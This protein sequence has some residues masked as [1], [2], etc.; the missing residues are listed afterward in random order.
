MIKTY[1]DLITY[2]EN[3]Q[4]S[5]EYY[6]L[7]KEASELDLMD[8]YIISHQYAA[9]VESSDLMDEILMEAIDP[10]KLKRIVTNFGTKASEFG[11]KI[12]QKLKEFI[13]K[14]IKFFKTY[15]NKLF[16]KQHKFDVNKFRNIVKSS[17]K[18]LA[19]YKQALK[20]ANISDSPN[21]R[22]EWDDDAII[23]F[24][25]SIMNNDSMKLY[26][27]SNSCKGLANPKDIASLIHKAEKTKVANE[28]N[29]LSKVRSIDVILNAD[30]ISRQCD[31]LQKALD[32]LNSS[33]DSL[34]HAIQS[35]THPRVEI[36]LNFIRNA[37]A[38]KYT[39]AQAKAELD[40]IERKFGKLAFVPGTVT[41]KPRP[42]TK[43]DL[44]DLWKEAVAGAG[45]RDFLEHMAEVGYAVNKNNK[46]KIINTSEFDNTRDRLSHLNYIYTITA[47]TLDFYNRFAIVYD[48]TINFISRI[49]TGETSE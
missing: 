4:Y 23:N 42:W 32:S 5:A 36:R 43:S 49:H 1:R 13:P 34:E 17:S 26:D 41:K 22:S 15:A 46:H 25:G 3:F 6:E 40:R 10:E 7:Y 11:S 21:K 20:E 29:K 8:Q 45:S 37:R 14:V 24:I 2:C 30:E 33:M 39:P 47:S 44:D 19:I 27:M 9:Y 35:E 48:A 12:V 16:K 31:Q 28:F 18:D 38:G